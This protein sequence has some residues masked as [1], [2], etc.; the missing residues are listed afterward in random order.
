MK[1]V[2]I[3]PPSGSGSGGGSCSPTPMRYETVDYSRYKASDNLEAKSYQLIFDYDSVVSDGFLFELK[4]LVDN[5]DE[6]KSAYLKVS[7]LIGTTERQLD[8][9][10][11]PKGEKNVLFP[12]DDITG[13]RLYI[14]GKVTYFISAIIVSRV[15]K[16]AEPVS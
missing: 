5:N 3:I 6:N 16:E 15:Q 4:L 14:K 10:E 1:V 11:I 8:E 12:F 2:P 7:K 13:L 9:I